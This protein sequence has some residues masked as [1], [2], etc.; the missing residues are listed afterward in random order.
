MRFVLTGALDYPIASIA[1]EPGESV[2]REREY[3][4]LPWS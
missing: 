2:N 4:L 3:S 1:L